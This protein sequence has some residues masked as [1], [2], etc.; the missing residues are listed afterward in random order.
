MECS[1]KYRSTHSDQSCPPITG[2]SLNTL[3]DV[4]GIRA[5]ATAS[6]SNPTACASKPARFS[7][8]STLYFL[9]SIGVSGG[10][11]YFRAMNSSDI[12]FDSTLDGTVLCTAL[13]RCAS[14]F[15]RNSCLMGERRS[16]SRHGSQQ[17]SFIVKRLKRWVGIFAMC[18]P[19]STVH[20]LSTAHPFTSPSLHVTLVFFTNR[21]LV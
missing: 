12:S 11:P 9:A 17:R 18:L 10:L 8:V 7:P 19:T 3:R 2:T 13:E 15:S 4:S 16:K 20:V 1:S 5:R 21:T 6:T 14:L